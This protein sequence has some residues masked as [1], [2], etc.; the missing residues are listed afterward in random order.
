MFVYRARF[1]GTSVTARLQ[2]KRGML[3]WYQVV[4]DG[5]QQ[6]VS[7]AAAQPLVPLAS[8]LAPGV[9]EISITKRS[10]GLWPAETCTRALDNS[11]PNKVLLPMLQERE[12]CFYGCL[13]WFRPA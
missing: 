13:L 3:D 7:V 2:L 9:H 10:V 4:I 12:H 11:L 1:Q 8:G 5:R 6:K